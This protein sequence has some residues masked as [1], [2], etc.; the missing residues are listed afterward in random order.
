MN[1]IEHSKIPRVF[2]ELNEFNKWLP[3]ISKCFNVLFSFK[4]EKNSL[5][6]RNELNK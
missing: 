2:D 5:V 6:A 4:A 1:L 3:R